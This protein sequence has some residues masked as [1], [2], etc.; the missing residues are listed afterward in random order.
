MSVD[1]LPVD[2]V[3]AGYAVEQSE[4]GPHCRIGGPQRTP[5]VVGLEHSGGVPVEIE[6]TDG[7]RTGL[8]GKYEQRPHRGAERGRGEHR[9]PGISALGQIGDEDRA[10]V[11]ERLDAGT[12]AQAELQFVELAGH[13]IAGPEG[14]LLV[15]PG[16][17][18]ECGPVQR[19]RRHTRLADPLRGVGAALG[20]DLAE[21]PL[22][23]VQLRHA[24]RGGIDR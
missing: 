3:G 16:H 17:Q 18:G 8:H 12:L 6:H 9:P 24:N 7:D 2:S 4:H 22:E 11:D 23:G 5:D 10:P 20:H 14:L 21:D 19:Q 1:S 13:L 15:R